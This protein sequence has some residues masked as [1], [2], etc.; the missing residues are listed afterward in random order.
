MKMDSGLD[1]G[2][3]LL[4]EKI[5]ITSACTY[6][7]LSQ[8][9]ATIGAVLMMKALEALFLQGFFKET[10]QPVEG[11]TYAHKIKKEEGFLQWKYSANVLDDLI[12]AFNPWPGTSFMFEGKRIKI[13][14][15]QVEDVPQGIIGEK[16]GTLIDDRLGIIGGKYNPFTE[17]ADPLK[18]LRPLLLQKPGGKVISKEEFLRGFPLSQGTFLD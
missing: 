4:Q 17:K 3:I 2:P 15:A 12:K 6:E 18:I 10:P 14:S 8:S 11:I 5:P 13:L 7:S 16:P 1:T 9:L